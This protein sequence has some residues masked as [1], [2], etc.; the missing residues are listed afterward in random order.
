M[1]HEL[2]EKTAGLASRVDNLVALETGDDSRRLD[3]LQDRLEDLS[4][5]AIAKDLDDSVKSYKDALQALND[6]IDTIGNADK[7]LTNI[8][9]VI[10]IVAKAAD[11][12]EKAIKMA[13]SV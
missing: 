6:A 9:R 10:A 4:L 8:A 12:V 7:T 11:L 1:S 3:A 5:A 13:A 2:A